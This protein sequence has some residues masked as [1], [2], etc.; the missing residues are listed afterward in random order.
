MKAQLDAF[1][2]EGALNSDFFGRIVCTAHYSRIKGLLDRTQGQIV[3]GGNVDNKNGFEP[4]VVRD[5]RDGDSLLE[6]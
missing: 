1:S 2:L 4:T 3:F 6:E 5:V